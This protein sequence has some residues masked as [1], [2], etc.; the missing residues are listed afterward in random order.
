[1]LLNKQLEN[2]NVKLAFNYEA[3]PF[4]KQCLK[5]KSVPFI[6]F[7]WTILLNNQLE[8]NNVEL[9]FNISLYNSCNAKFKHRKQEQVKL[10]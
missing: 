5:P 9:A 2:N 4:H 7:S 10:L 3:L 8:N 6:Q 1:M